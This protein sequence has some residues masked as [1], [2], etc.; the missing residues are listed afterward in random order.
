V[1]SI[2]VACFLPVDFMNGV[3]TG[4][5]NLPFA[6]AMKDGRPFTLAGLSEN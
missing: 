2:A 5:P 3:H 1:S 6:I 4:G